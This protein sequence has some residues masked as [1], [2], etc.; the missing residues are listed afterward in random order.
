MTASYVLHREEARCH[1]PIAHGTP[2]RC[3]NRCAPVLCDVY[4]RILRGRCVSLHEATNLFFNPFMMLTQLGYKTTSGAQL[5]GTGLVISFLLV[6]RVGV[7]TWQAVQFAIDIAS[8]DWEE[9][10]GQ[11]PVVVSFAIFLGMTLLSWLWLRDIL[12]GLA[13][14]VKAL[15]LGSRQ[16]S[17]LPPAKLA[18]PSRPAPPQPGP[19]PAAAAGLREPRGAAEPRGGLP[20]AG[21]AAAPGESML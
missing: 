12:N 5:V 21:G 15:G 16:V 17:P 3:C 8:C 7:C 10:A 18:P 4:L 1:F 6:L 11:M 2:C 19:A 14:A 9:P 13:L 20:D